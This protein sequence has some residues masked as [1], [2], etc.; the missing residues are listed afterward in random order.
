MKVYIVTAEHFEAP[1]AKVSAHRT[2]EGAD[3]QAAEH[4]NR[5]LKDSREAGKVDVPRDV[6]AGTWEDAAEWLE[7]TYGVFVEVIRLE[8]QP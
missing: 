5:L 6:S 3:R 4:V 2:L 7:D 8:V 1:G